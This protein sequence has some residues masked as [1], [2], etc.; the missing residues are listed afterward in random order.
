MNTFISFFFLFLMTLGLLEG[1][2]NI[3]QK[4]QLMLL[5][6]LPDWLCL[7]WLMVMRFRRSERL[8]LAGIILFRIGWEIPETYTIIMM[9]SSVCIMIVLTNSHSF[10]RMD[11]RKYLIG[12]SLSILL[13]SILVRLLGLS[14]ISINNSFQLDKITNHLLPW[15]FVDGL[16]I[17]LFSRQK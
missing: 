4:S 3:F 10:E 9:I 16:T 8:L 2:N 5:I 7:P 14:L 1:L 11:A 15:L 13:L 12:L 17:L 6:T